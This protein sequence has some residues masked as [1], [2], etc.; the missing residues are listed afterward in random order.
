MTREHIE[1]GRPTAEGM[2]PVSTRSVP[3]PFPASGLENGGIGIWERTSRD[4]HLLGG[5]GACTQE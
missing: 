3:G 5:E 1:I 4:R 2:R